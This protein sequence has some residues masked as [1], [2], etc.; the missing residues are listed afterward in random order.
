MS[1]TFQAYSNIKP[2]QPSMAIPA[3]LQ[4]DISPSEHFISYSASV[5]K[6]RYYHHNTHP[7]TLEFSS[8]KYT[9]WVKM[10]EDIRNRVSANSVIVPVCFRELV[11]IGDKLSFV[12]DFA[13]CAALYKDFS[14]HYRSVRDLTSVDFMRGYNALMACFKAGSENGVV[15]ITYV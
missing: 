8:A 5:E 15:V 7:L 1:V 14:E 6:G 11:V 9:D 12:F 3:H 4:F 13:V 10:L 2:W